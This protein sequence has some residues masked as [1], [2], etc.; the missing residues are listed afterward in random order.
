MAS[1]WFSDS[2]YVSRVKDDLRD[3]KIQPIIISL[4]ECFL[5]DVCIPCHF[6]YA[7]G[8]VLPKQATVHTPQV[9]LNEVHVWFPAS[10]APTNPHMENGT[11]DTLFAETFHSSLPD[12]T[13][14]FFIQRRYCRSS[15]ADWT[16]TQRRSSPWP[17]SGAIR[18]FVWIVSLSLLKNGHQSSVIIAEI[19]VRY[20]RSS[21]TIYPLYH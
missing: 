1:R 4:L 8:S 6:T 5:C 17:C 14:S 21:N 3:V 15:Y 18:W 10:G 12:K 11:V 7:G 9:I 13:E 20:N 19:N 2:T 16:R